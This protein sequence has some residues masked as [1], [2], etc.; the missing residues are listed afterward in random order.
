MKIQYLVRLLAAPLLAFLLAPSVWAQDLR[1]GTLK[2]V[3]GKVTVSNGDVRRQATPGGGV[4]ATDRI[5][6][7]EGGSAVVLLRDGTSLTFGPKTT[8]DLT[9]FQFDSTTQ[10]GRLSVNLLQ[11][12]V[13]VVTGILGKVAPQNVEVVTPY[14]SVGARGTDFIVE[15]LL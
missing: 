4:L 15:V 5:V 1:A 6:T 7:E 14:S 8:V 3:Q 10:E 13:R 12:I 11:G 2:N 9:R